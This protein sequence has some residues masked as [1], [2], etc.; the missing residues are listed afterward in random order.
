MDYL[1]LLQKDPNIQ[2]AL[3]SVHVL[4]HKAIRHPE[5]PHPFMPASAKQFLELFYWDSYFIM[6]GLL[7]SDE[8]SKTLIKNI[9]DDF[10]FLF[11]KYGKI[12]NSFPNWMTRTQPPFLSSMVLMVYDLY[13]DKKWLEKAYLIVSQEYQNVWLSEPRLTEIGLS[14]YYDPEHPQGEDESAT[15]E[16]GWDLTPRFERKAHQVCPVDLNAYLYKY[17]TDLAWMAE[18]LGKNDEIE[19][20]IRAAEKR[21]GLIDQFLWASE[22]EFYYDYNFVEKRRVTPKSCAAYVPMWVKAASDEQTKSLVERLKWFEHE[23]GLA[24]TDQDYGMKEQ[25]SF[26]NGWPPVMWMV[27]TGLR[28]YDYHDD[29]DRLTYKWLK[30]CADEFVKEGQWH[31]KLSVIKTLATEDDKRYPHQT[32]QYWTMGVF[33]SLYDQMTKD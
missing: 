4:P 5:L 11:E 7:V 24:V 33:L 12:P 30:L 6:L 25:W 22:D 9:V 31:E 10:I 3:Q 20:W 1:K 16:S 17:E 21:K 19:N 14:R 27:I 8:D 23:G 2:K 29:A 15:D 28:H 32:E 13:D 18:E 26:P